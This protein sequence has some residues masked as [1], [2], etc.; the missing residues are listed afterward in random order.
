MTL[1][2]WHRIALAVLSGLLLSASMPNFDVPLVGWMA[3]VP[4]LV[5]IHAQSSLGAY[6]I[7]LPFGLVWSFAVHI[8]YPMIFPPVLGWF[9]IVAVGT[10][11]AGIILGGAWLQRRLRGTLSLLALPVL[12]SAIEFCKFIAPGVEDWWFVLLAKSQ[13]RSPAALQILS[14]TGFP[15]LS[16][17]VMLTNVCLATLLLRWKNIDAGAPPFK[18]AIGGLLVVTG[19]VGWGWLQL[20]GAPAERFR[21][22]A[23]TDMVNADPE[24]RALGELAGFI[25]TEPE[26]SHSIFDVNAALTRSIG[27]QRPAFVVWPENEFCDADDPELIGRL[28][29]LAREMDA[30][31]VADVVWNAETGLHDTALMMAPDGSETGRRAK[32]NITQGEEEVGFAAGPP[33]FPIF[34]TPHARVGIAVCWDVHRLWIIRELARAGAELVL[35]P[36]DNDFDGTRWFPAFHASD[37]VFRAAEHRLAFGL[38]T[39]NGLSLVI[40]PY[41][42]ITAEGA[43]NE[44]GVIVGETFVAPQRTL[45]TRFGDWFGWGMVLAS[46][47]LFVTA[48]RNAGLPTE[49]R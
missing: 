1:P 37:A 22:A 11:Y 20:P 43:I 10:F 4:L 39:V 40:D 45:Y 26:T 15:G 6:V 2:F 7:A 31:I 46:L 3:L 41:G 12:W 25:V 23:N 49:H 44:R 27:E 35:L 30:H 8:W 18:A 38:G 5:A 47:A 16:F 17:A 24:I 32:I 42:R 29:A 36:M 33:A 21:V 34:E 28:G 9:L 48:R 19:S 14:I 13:W